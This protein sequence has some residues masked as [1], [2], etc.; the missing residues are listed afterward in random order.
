MT[1]EN[2]F[3]WNIVG[4]M[5]PSTLLPFAYLPVF[6]A[7]RL[8]Q[9]PVGLHRY[10]GV[11]GAVPGAALTWDHHQSGEP[12]NLE[13]MPGSFDPSD[14]DAVATT[15]P[16]TDALAS[17]LAVMAGGKDRLPDA[18]RRVLEAASYRC[19][20]LIPH[21]HATPEEDH[22]G[23]RLQA[24]VARRLNIAAD[25]A[26]TFATL[27]AEVAGCVVR[28]EPLPGDDPATPA[29]RTLLHHLLEHRL[30]SHGDVALV[31]IRHMQSLP[32]ELLYEH[33]PMHAVGVWVGAHPAGGHRY[34]VGVNP[35][36]AA[37][38]RDLRPVLTALAAAEFA[39]G[40]PCLGA[41]PVPGH[42][43]WGGRATVFGSPWN[44]GSRLPPERVVAI[45]QAT[46]PR[47]DPR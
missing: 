7:T 39:L 20:H 2:P 44:Y 30:S 45:V 23:H 32:P 22:A 43:N 10:I 37:P 9:V 25:E 29:Q 28:G 8:D 46:I 34:T 24:W 4:W 6:V 3:H 14:Y 38:P 47:D 27:C 41:A 36:H 40:P 31:D 19:D 5:D 18:V 42:E 13:A 35:F 21:P 15:L 12:I 16:D 33:I 17:V 26:T 1:V 11:D